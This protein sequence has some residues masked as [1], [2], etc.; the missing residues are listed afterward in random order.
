MMAPGP[1]RLSSVGLLVET[2]AGIYASSSVIFPNDFIKA[3]GTYVS[4]KV[5]TDDDLLVLTTIANDMYQV[6]GRDPPPPVYSTREIA[7][8]CSFTGTPRCSEPIRIA[9]TAETK[10]PQQGEPKWKWRV[11]PHVTKLAIEFTSSD[12][13][14]VPPPTESPEWEI[15][16]R[17]LPLGVFPHP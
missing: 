5:T 16:G 15:T 12:P 11:T 6:D 17:V 13:K 4:T 1:N 8:F 7:V 3:T 9:E 14:A 10:T 2:P